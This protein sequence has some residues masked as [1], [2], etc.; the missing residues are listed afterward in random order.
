MTLIENI[1]DGMVRVL[2]E[3]LVIFP[4][5]WNYR[6]A[7]SSGAV[8]GYSGP[9]YHAQWSWDSNSHCN[10]LAE[11]CLFVGTPL[12]YSCQCNLFVG[13]IFTILVFLDTTAT[14]EEPFA[15]LPHVIP[16]AL[17]Y[18]ELLRM[19]SMITISD[20]FWSFR[21]YTDYGKYCGPYNFHTKT[22][23][24]ILCANY[25]PTHRINIRGP[26][27]WEWCFYG[28]EDSAHVKDF[29]P[30]GRTWGGEGYKCNYGCTLF[31]WVMVY[32][33]GLSVVHNTF[34]HT[35]TV[36]SLVE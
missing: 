35:S 6:P 24:V 9:G 17:S 11:G 33:V 14:L 21:R 20:L 36:I 12:P 18:Y 31:S 28:T 16:V 5:S 7:S 4:G 34:A 15:N 10:H 2:D 29:Q 1:Y 3:F 23:G 30:T 8:A 32:T 13:L 22:F 19:I 27:H 26:R 25:L